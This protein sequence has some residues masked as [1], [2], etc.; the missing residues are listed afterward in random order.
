MKLR[1]LANELS[2]RSLSIL[3]LCLCFT[4]IQSGVNVSVR[5]LPAVFL[6]ILY[7]MWSHG[8]SIMSWRQKVQPFYKPQIFRLSIKRIQKYL[9]CT[10]INN[11][12]SVCPFSRS[13]ASVSVSQRT[14]GGPVSQTARGKQCAKTTHTYS[15]AEATQVT[16]IN[17][18]TLTHTWMTVL[19][20][21]HQCGISEQLE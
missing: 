9:S 14:P 2:Q 18:E 11:S 3:H 19:N 15:G 6:Q 21:R 7:V 1:S 17:T 13:S 12:L 8:R 20:T 16:H 10:Q 4:Y 5:G